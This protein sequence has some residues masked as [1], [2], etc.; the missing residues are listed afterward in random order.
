MTCASNWPRSANASP[1]RFRSWRYA[2]RIPSPSFEAASER[3]SPTISSSS[4]GQGALSA[5]L[6]QSYI[7]A[8][9]QVASLPN[10]VLATYGDMVRVPGAN[11]S[12]EQQ[13]ALGANVL[14]VYSVEDALT[15]AAENPDRTVVFIAV[16][17]ETTAPS[18][19]AGI[20]MAHTRRLG[21]FCVLAAHKSVVPAMMAL[22]ASGDV[23]LDGF[24][25]PGHVSVIIGSEAYRP[26]VEQHRRPCVVAGFEP[27]GMM[28]GLLRLAQM[29]QRARS[30]AR[31][32]LFRRGLPTRQ[33]TCPSPHRRG[34]RARRRGLARHRTDLRQRPGHSPRICRL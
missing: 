1:G 29:A 18:T 10:V 9:L 24:L 31:Q 16:G 2:E 21:N 33:P 8:A 5:S 23:P 6:P 20:L 3:C 22:L 14:V 7:D 25:C 13:R 4:A 34:L 27:E 11:G 28:A 15:F 19:A 17:F 32:P 30:R 26:I 12:L